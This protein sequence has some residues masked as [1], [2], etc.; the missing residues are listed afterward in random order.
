MR[1]MLG[2]VLEKGIA[3]EFEHRATLRTTRDRVCL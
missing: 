1:L 2:F 3:F